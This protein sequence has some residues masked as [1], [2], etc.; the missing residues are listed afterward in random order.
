MT[1]FLKSMGENTLLNS[2][3]V[4]NLER[5]IQIKSEIKSLQDIEESISLLSNVKS[6]SFVLMQGDFLP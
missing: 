5:K 6:L 2:M 4:D 1:S 3:N